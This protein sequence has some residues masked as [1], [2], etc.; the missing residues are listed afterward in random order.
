[1][2][3]EEESKAHG[4]GDGSWE[5]KARPYLFSGKARPVF[6]LAIERDSVARA[7][8]TPSM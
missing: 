2:S 1:M 5:Q 8:M 6:S 7:E 3:P 4:F